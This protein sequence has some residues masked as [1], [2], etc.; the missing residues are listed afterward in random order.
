MLYN[1]HSA[2]SNPVSIKLLL[3][4]YIDHVNGPTPR[5]Y[6]ERG[7]LIFNRAPALPRRA[8]PCASSG[9][10]GL[11]HGCQRK[12]EF[13]CARPPASCV[14]VPAPHPWRTEGEGL[15]EVARRALLAFVSA[16]QVLLDLV[17]GPTVMT[18]LVPVGLP[19]SWRPPHR[20]PVAVALKA[21][22]AAKTGWAG[23]AGH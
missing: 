17:A 22:Q 14:A 11:S 8:A 12:Q 23:G 16:P 19:G 13:P 1:L 7:G 15:N 6:T 21:H 5:K 2:Q 4:L 10:R 3:G 18:V 20:P 9:S